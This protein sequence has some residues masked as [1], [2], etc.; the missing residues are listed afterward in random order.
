MGLI[1]LLVLLWVAA[2]GGCLLLLVGLSAWLV[3]VGPRRPWPRP[4]DGGVL[5]GNGACPGVDR[6]PSLPPSLPPPLPLP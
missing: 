3:F 1:M 4:A 5:K 2:A 6:A